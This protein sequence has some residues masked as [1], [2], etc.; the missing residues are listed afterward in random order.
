MGTQRCP[1]ATHRTDFATETTG[2]WSRPSVARHASRAQRNL[3]GVGHRGTVARTAQPISAVPDLP[4]PLPAVGAGR[5]TGRHLARTGGGIART[6]K[7]ETGG[8]FHRRLLHGGKKGGLAV[9]PTKRGKGTKIIALADD[10][11]LPLAVSI[12]SASPHESQLVDGVLG[13]SFL[14][15][16]P[17]RLIGDKA[18]DSDR[19]DR[20]LADRYGIEMIAPHRGQRREPTQ[21]GRPLRRYR[22]RWRVE[23]LFAWLHHFRRLVIRWEYHVENFFGMVRLGCM[24]ILFRY[25]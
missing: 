25:L 15:T 3:V 4:S 21:D 13:H 6:G 9:G 11:S 2:R 1:V 19:L 14:D 7:A 10:H 5:Q 16:L 18:Y 12:E 17:A 8:G 24:Q 23:R 20:D 22:R